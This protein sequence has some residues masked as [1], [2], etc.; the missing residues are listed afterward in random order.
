MRQEK[1]G[2]VAME[3]R[4]DKPLLLKQ[5]LDSS[6]SLLDNLRNAPS[7]DNLVLTQEQKKRLTEEIV[8]HTELKAVRRYNVTPLRSRIGSSPTTYHSGFMRVPSLSPS[9][10]THERRLMS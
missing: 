6:L 9:R 8:R 3:P 7:A 1:L 10:K 5:P 4:T 2:K